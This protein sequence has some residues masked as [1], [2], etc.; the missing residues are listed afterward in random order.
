MG[1]LSCDNKTDETSEDGK[2]KG[3]FIANEDF[4]KDEPQ[5]L[6]NE[7]LEYILILQQNG[8]FSAKSSNPSEA[9]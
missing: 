7:K 2:M 3:G 4:Q 1:L 5:E 8:N 9:L 6:N